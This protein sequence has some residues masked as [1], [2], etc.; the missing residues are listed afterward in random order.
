[1]TVNNPSVSCDAMLDGLVKNILEATEKDPSFDRIIQEVVIGDEPLANEE[2]PG[3]SPASDAA[4]AAIVPAADGDVLPTEQAVDPVP[5]QTPL[6]IRTAVA[7]TAGTNADPNFSI[8]KLIVLNSNESVQKWLLVW[9]RPISA[10]QAK[11][12]I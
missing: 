7:A 10:L 12:S 11:A 4:G 2:D 5:P 9:I 6:I 8:S 1:M 3:V